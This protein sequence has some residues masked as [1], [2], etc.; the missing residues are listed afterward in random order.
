MNAYQLKPWTQIVTPHQDILEGRLDTSVYAASL[1]AV[2][3]QD[4]N[5]PRV[6]RDAREFFAATYLTKE[7]R[8]LLED[9]LRGLGGESG[10]RVL[11]LR[12][13][14]GGGKTHSLVSLYHIATN[15]HKLQFPELATLPDPGLVKVAIFIGTNISASTGIQIENGPQILTPWG[16]LAWQIGGA[17]TYALV[18]TEDQQ[19]IAPGSD[20]LRKIF[21]DKSILLLMDEFLV[22]V[23]DAMGLVVGDTTFGRR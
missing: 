1:G 8:K 3:R 16:Y 9:V 4:S 5:C 22:Y 13:P 14:F 10:D 15:R 18:E 23:S 2:V 12:T 6:Y 17:E 7:L 19:R 21:G 11:Q 20:L